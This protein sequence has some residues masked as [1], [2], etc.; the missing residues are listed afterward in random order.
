MYNDAI[1]FLAKLLLAGG[2]IAAIVWQ[3]LKAFGSKWLSNEFDKRLRALEHEHNK[4]IERLRSDLTR[5]FDRRSKLHQR[6]FDVL[7]EV[8][9]KTCDAYWHTRSLVSPAQSYPDLNRM[10]APQL[11]SFVAGCELL[12]WQKIELKNEKDKT[13]Y[14][15]KEVFWHRLRNAQG[16][17]TAASNSLGKQGI[18]INKE[19]RQRLDD[20]TSLLW[21][22]L[23]EEEMNQA[24]GFIPR[25][26]KDSD[27]LMS[28]GEQLRESLES[29]IRDILWQE[30]PGAP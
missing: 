27:R 7:P 28:E 9:A 20:L 15:I 30:S 29:E 22:S 8:W 21:S 10:S 2:G 16:L 25:V 13:R 24:E 14:Y 18:F 17:V 3:L 12:D 26:R 23:S 6:E 19:T 1:V 5:A 4:E 11:D